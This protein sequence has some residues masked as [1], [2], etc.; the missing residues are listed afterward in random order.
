MPPTWSSCSKF[1]FFTVLFSTKHPALSFTILIGQFHHHP[2]S[3]NTLQWIGIS[4]RRNEKNVAL[5]SHDLTTTIFSDVISHHF[6]SFYLSKSGFFFCSLHVPI[7]VSPQVLRVCSSFCLECSS[8]RSPP[9]ASF[10]F[11]HSLAYM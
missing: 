7:L 6:L 3:A 8:G 9:M 2:A 10:S 11:F 5:V 1:L 4:M